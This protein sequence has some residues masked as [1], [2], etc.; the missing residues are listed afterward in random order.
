MFGAAV[1]LSRAHSTSSA[2]GVNKSTISRADIV[3]LNRG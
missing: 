1:V 2:D 3:R